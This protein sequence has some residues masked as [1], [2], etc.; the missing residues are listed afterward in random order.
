MPKFVTALLLLFCICCYA[1]PLKINSTYVEDSRT[2]TINAENTITA[3]ISEKLIAVEPKIDFVPRIYWNGTGIKIQADFV[4]GTFYTVTLKKDFPGTHAVNKLERDYTFTFIAANRRASLDFA[5]SGRFFPLHAPIW[6]LP[7]KSVNIGDSI[8]VTTSQFYQ[9]RILD[10][11]GYYSRLLGREIAENTIK[12]KAKQNQD[13][14]AAINLEEVGIPRGK[15]GFYHLELNTEPYS[16]RTHTGQVVIVTDLAIF[17]T[18]NNGEYYCIVRKLS[19]PALPVPNAK[20]SVYSYKRQLLATAT[21]NQDGVAPVI[22]APLQDKA[23]LPERVLVNDPSNG[24]CAFID[25]PHRSQYITAP[26]APHAML[27]AD[28]DVL[29]PGETI[30]LTTTV[31]TSDTATAI[32][33]LPLQFLVEDSQGNTVAKKIVKTD[34]FGFAQVAVPIPDQAI[35]GSYDVYLSSPG[36][37]GYPSYD[38]TNFLVSEFTP[39]QINLVLESSIKGNMLSYSGTAKYY[40]GQPVPAS[41]VAVEF[42]SSWHDFEPPK[43]WREYTFGWNSPAVSQPFSYTTAELTTDKDGKFTGKVQIGLDNVANWPP[44]PAI[45]RTAA[46]VKG[47]AGTRAV[48]ATDR[49]IFHFRDFYLGALEQDSSLKLVALTPEGKVAPLP[50]ELLV[51]ISSSEWLYNLKEQSDGTMRRL[52]EQVTISVAKK[53]ITVQNDGTLPLALPAAGQYDVKLYCAKTQLPLC[54]TQFWYSAGESA[55]RSPNPTQLDFAL[56]KENYLPGDTAVATF[57]STFPGTAIVVTGTNGRNLSHTIQQVQVGKNSLQLT[58]PKDLA[59]GT[60]YA[61]VTVVGKISADAKGVPQDAPRLSGVVTLP[62]RQKP[63]QLDVTI[64]AP[65]SL[66]PGDEATISVQLKDSDGAPVVGE[67][68]LWGVNQGILALTGYKTPNPFKYFFGLH[69][70]FPFDVAD[71]YNYIYPM[72][73]VVN[74]QIGGG[75]SLARMRDYQGQARTMRPNEGVLRLGIIKTDANGRATITAK[76]PEFTGALRLMAVAATK[77]AT[78]SDEATVTLRNPVTISIM[79]PAAAAP[80]DKIT[81]RATV[82]NH[83]LPTSAVEGRLWHCTAPGSTITV[84]PTPNPKIAKG[85]SADMQATLQI[86]EDFE[87]SLRVKLSLR[88]GGQ[89]WLE[90]VE[91]MVRPPYIATPT[92]TIATLLPGQVRQF[93]VDSSASSCLIVGSDTARI[94]SHI[95]WL[96]QYPYGCLEQVSAAAFPQ[97]AVPALIQN[98]LL[99][100]QMHLEATQKIQH[101]MD[102]IR[103]LRYGDAFTMWPN[104]TT[105]WDDG[106]I[107]AML[108]QLEAQRLG[109]LELTARDKKRFESFLRGYVNKRSNPKA[110]RAIATYCLAILAPNLTE[111]YVKILAI[112]EVQD[113]AFAQF[114]AAMAL[115]RGGFAADGNAIWKKVQNSNF[116]AAPPST[117]LTGLDSPIRRAGIAL[118]LLADLLPTSP[119]CHHL[120]AEL[121]RLESEG[122][123][124]LTTQEHAWIALGM[125]NYALTQPKPSQLAATITRTH[126]NRKQDL[127]FS[128]KDGA[129]T[130]EAPGVYQ[131]KNTGTG[132]LLVRARARRMFWSNP[133]QTRNA[134]SSGFSITREYLDATG[135][136]ATSCRVGDLLTVRLTIKGAPCDNVVISD[137]LPGGFEIEDPRFL[138][139]MS[140]P[141]K[142]PENQILALN[143]VERRYD[144]CLIFAHVLSSG[145]K[146]QFS[147]QIRAVA[148]GTYT[149]PSAQIEAMYIPRRFAAT[150]TGTITVKE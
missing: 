72:L 33:N 69:K 73:R 94:L 110:S 54:Q 71:N 11:N 131:I 26:T 23:D 27:F 100:K 70:I 107:F 50:K 89:Q 146:G 136:P 2:F 91:I 3:P 119:I 84:S 44:C 145:L 127:P 40:F 76:M 116:I 59:K 56:D 78:G 137:L 67:V 9:N 6:E 29:R 149:T 13:H 31:R 98:G 47:A 60:W 39:D 114:M 113:S 1:A 125:A 61:A 8:R 22:I 4:P 5:S 142:S 111:N 18:C 93:Q 97:L 65:Q 85:E 148:P 58:I 16:Y 81:I 80:K 92:E 117:D 17:L 87:G 101:A 77:I 45:I 79:A 38:T 28:R 103:T 90:E 30:T 123:A 74:G 20:I 35:L 128:G 10:F 138:T 102:I 115:I 86:P 32:G 124:F 37:N 14:V 147:Y 120:A 132:P 126:N 49:E 129:V 34:E 141:V 57:E 106:S 96:N 143:L 82:F 53:V 83:D 52:W 48:S 99:P 55:R 75:K 19:N 66:R 43:A 41:K 42:S 144:R 104:S 51:E 15:P 135:A 25:L 130:Y 105:V 95:D 150:P 88:F 46:T 36:T 109:M 62:V 21:T 122:G 63:R 140:R 12:I 24:D 118:W 64:A 68:A 134:V 112:E 121:K 108:F 7:I 139:R 133:N